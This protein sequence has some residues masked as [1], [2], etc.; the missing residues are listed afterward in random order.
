MNQTDMA[1]IDNVE[2]TQITSSRWLKAARLGWIVL[3]VLSLLALVASLPGQYTAEVAS[4]DSFDPQ[5]LLIFPGVM[6]VVVPLG[7]AVLLFLQRRDDRI[8]LFLAYFFLLFGVAMTGPLYGIALF[9]GSDEILYIGYAS[10]ASR[11]CAVS[12]SLPFLLTAL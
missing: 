11:V 7:L 10:I 6:S 4:Y 8:A 2:L 5:Q 12:M 9:I 3:A 1:P